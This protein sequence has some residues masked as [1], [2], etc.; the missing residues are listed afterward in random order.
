MKTVAEII[1]EID[2]VVGC[3]DRMNGMASKASDEGSPEIAGLYDLVAD[4]LDNYIILLRR[5]K[6]K[7]EY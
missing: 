2:T 3:R 1:E 5:Q 6:L 7:E 4:K